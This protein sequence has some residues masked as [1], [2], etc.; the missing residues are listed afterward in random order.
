M[1]KSTALPA[2][3]LLPAFFLL[4]SYNQLFGFVPVKTVLFYALLIYGILAVCY[5][6]LLKL[7]V[8]AP[9]TELLLFSFSF[10]ILF[11]APLHDGYMAITFKSIISH[12]WVML[13]L[14]CILLLLLSRKIITTK[15]ISP[16]IFPL[17]N[18]VMAGVLL[19][20][21]FIAFTK[22]T[23][24]KKDHNLIYP[25]KPLAEKYVSPNL[26]DSSKP[27]IYFLLLDEYTNN[28]TLKKIWNY[29]NSQV[30]DW[31]SKND[32]YVPANS[33]CNYSFTV[34]SISSTFNMNYIEKKIGWDG[35]NDFTLLK[36][37]KSL[38]NNETF[39][40]LKKE[41]YLIRFIAPFRNTIE[42]NGLKNFF[43]FMQDGVIPQQTLPGSIDIS[44]TRKLEFKNNPTLAEDMNR[45]YHDIG[46]TA[47]KI[48]QTTDSS[49]NRRPHFVYGHFMITH[50]PHIFGP[51][52]KMMPLN[53]SLKTDP[54][55]SY[56]AQVNYANTIMTEVVENIKKHNKPNTIIII[57]GD[58]GFRHLPDSLNN[59]F[60]LPNFTAIYFP[61]K[62]YSKLYDTI[63]PVNIF[64]V[65]FDQYFHQDF[66][67][68]KDQST[69]VK[70]Y[71]DSATVL[72]HGL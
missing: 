30:T 10:F 36:A 43:D 4:H 34:Y 33:R 55:R 54:F 23:E 44:I 18:L 60:C 47:D 29:D 21:L 69:I 38:S 19:S 24:Y 22:V 2:L 46:F 17:L 57:E 66:P 31:L 40:I 3:L 63:T 37:Q 45:K 39:S 7:R 14:C 28:K 58:H 64:R 61:D 65:I 9:K 5:F 27:D 42:I 12:Y 49:S 1:K 62:N 26:P 72:K 68:L 13:P 25:G 35:T 6:I 8:P 41:D 48:K 11:F 67:L 15:N 52:G 20:E 59:P 71:F 51:N 70:D 53:G 16:K 50:V 32:F 56:T